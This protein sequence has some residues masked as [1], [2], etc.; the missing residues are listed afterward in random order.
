MPGFAR[1][2]HQGDVSGSR[3]LARHAATMTFMA[4]LAAAI[5]LLIG[6]PLLRPLL[7]D[8]YADVPRMLPALLLAVLV[9]CLT[10]PTIPVMQT[11]GLERLYGR[12]LAVHLPL[13]LL[14]VFGLSRLSGTTGAAVAY[15]IGRIVWNVAVFVLIRRHR[16]LIM[17]PSLK[18]AAAEFRRLLRW[19]HRA[20][21][22]ADS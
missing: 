8:G 12:C 17:L 1:L 5:G 20:M 16:S 11:T 4:A 14:L 22:A 15:L 3:L 21:A 18:C 9:D 10:G 7:G 2:H 6:S 13:Q 19:S